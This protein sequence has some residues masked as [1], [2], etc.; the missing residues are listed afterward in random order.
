[1]TTIASTFFNRIEMRRCYD[2]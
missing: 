2:A 1:M